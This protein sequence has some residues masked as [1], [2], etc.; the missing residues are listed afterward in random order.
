MK[1][2]T[3]Y[4]ITGIALLLG[5][6]QNT[7]AQINE[8]LMHNPVWRDSSTCA[9]PFPCLKYEGYNYYV[10]GDSTWNGLV[11]KKIFKK[12]AGVFMWMAPTPPQCSGSFSYVETNHAFLLRSSGKQMY[13]KDPGEPTEHLLYDFD[14][15]LGDTLPTT[16]NN[17]PGTTIYVTAIDSFYTPYG[18]KKIFTLGG[19]NWAEFLI[20]GVGS[21]HGLT[22][23]LANF[24]DC[25]YQLLCFSLN[26][27]SWYPAQGLS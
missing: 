1:P 15:S 2:N 17:M 4:V 5:S 27:T 21:S 7:S 8:Y 23:P 19:D 10:A 13:V 9:V 11:Y 22:E 3:I 16:F 25:G 18:Y 20:E 12:G 14:L 24:F 26:D 6:F